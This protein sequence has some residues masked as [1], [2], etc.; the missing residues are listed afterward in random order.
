MTKNTMER[1]DEH[2][3]VA[4]NTTMLKSRLHYADSILASVAQESTEECN[5]Y[6]NLVRALVQQ[7]YK[8]IPDSTECEKI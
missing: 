1:L 4:R 3:D 6:I 7:T 5:F 2:Y 8:E